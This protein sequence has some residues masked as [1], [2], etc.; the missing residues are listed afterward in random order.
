LLIERGDHTGARAALARRGTPNPASD[1]DGLVR[2][3]EIELL[4]AEGRW[5]DALRAAD[6]YQVRLRGVD[7]PVWAPW[8][9]LKALALDGLGRHEEALVLLDEELD[10]SR[11]W[12][13]PGAMARTL[14]LLGTL[15]RDNDHELLYEAAALAEASPAR[16]EHAKALV[17]LGSALRRARRRSDAREPL[18][19]GFE[20]ANR[21]GAP[22]LSD[23]ART[24]LYAAGGRPRRAALTGPES[25]TPSERRVADLAAEGHSN[26]DIAQMLFVTPKTVEVHL[27]SVYRKLGISARRAL[28]DVLADLS[29]A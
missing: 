26:R 6:D 9:S 27:T 15:R 28:S 22:A 18:A 12:G 7:N 4:L 3:A 10:A 20:L 23:R 25:L 8:R 24:E 11:R 5:D 16:L 19:R 1:G 17:A 2:R 21:C 29:S 14:R 13:A